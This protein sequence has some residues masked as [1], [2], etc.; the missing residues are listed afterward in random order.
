MTRACRF[1]AD[2]HALRCP[3]QTTVKCPSSL[4]FCTHFFRS[5]EHFC[6][7]R[8][9]PPQVRFFP[10]FRR[11]NW[12]RTATA[13]RTFCHASGINFFCSR[14]TLAQAQFYPENFFNKRREL[15]FF[16]WRKTLISAGSSLLIFLILNKT[17]KI[18][19]FFCLLSFARWRHF[20]FQS[21]FK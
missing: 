14:S 11:S 9:A 20:V 1:S 18:C 4:Q 8:C 12:S 16:S 3:K 13:F 2:D 17:V 15:Q 21:W 6:D 5:A 7:C 10:K 19:H